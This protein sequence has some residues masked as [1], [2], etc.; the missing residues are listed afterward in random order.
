MTTELEKKWAAQVAGVTAAEAVDEATR[1]LAEERDQL[2]M[3]DYGSESAKLAG[4]QRAAHMDLCASKLRVMELR[5]VEPPPPPEISGEMHT[6]P[7]RRHVGLDNPDSPFLVSGEDLD[8][9]NIAGADRVCSYCGGWHPDEF[10]AFLVDGRIDLSDKGYK[11]YVRRPG[12]GNAVEGA[13][14]FYTWHIADDRV[15][16]FEAAVNRALMGSSG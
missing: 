12:V 16:E 1:S 5:H 14:K 3:G 10:L 6:C 11:F 7:R 13:I 8:T 4:Y 2:M 9:W 15:P